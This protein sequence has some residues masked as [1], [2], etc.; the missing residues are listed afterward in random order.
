MQGV[1]AKIG[2]PARAPFCVSR[3]GESAVKEQYM[4]SMVIEHRKWSRA[5]VAELLIS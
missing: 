5:D 2:H 3:G 1:P 4:D